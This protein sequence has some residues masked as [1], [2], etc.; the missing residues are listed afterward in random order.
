MKKEQIAAL[1]IKFA[2]EIRKQ[3]YIFLCHQG[4]LEQLIKCSGGAKWIGFADSGLQ[5]LKDASERRGYS[6]FAT[7]IRYD[8]QKVWFEFVVQCHK[9]RLEQLI[10]KYSPHVRVCAR[11]CA[12]EFAFHY[13]EAARSLCRIIELGLFNE[14]EA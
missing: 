1:R 2:K 9:Y 7:H 4:V 6:V 5:M 3:R 10:F 13:G 14:M 11:D 8:G 12:E